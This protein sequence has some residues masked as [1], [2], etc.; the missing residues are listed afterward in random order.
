M[1]Q[2]VRQGT[3]HLFC[4]WS[5]GFCQDFAKW[6]KPQ[7]PWK[8]QTLQGFND[9]A[10]TNDLHE[11]PVVGAPPVVVMRTETGKRPRQRLPS[12]RPVIVLNKGGFVTWN[13][14]EYSEK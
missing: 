9:K 4:L 8:S 2:R 13:K 1:S 3:G 6:Q 11:P 12:V 7:N 14:K 5:F 10:P